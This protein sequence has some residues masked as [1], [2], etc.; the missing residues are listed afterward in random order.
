MKVKSAWKHLSSRLLLLLDL[1]QSRF[2]VYQRQIESGIFIEFPAFSTSP[3]QYIIQF[4]TFHG[5]YFLAVSFQLLAASRAAD[6]LI[7]RW[8]SQCDCGPDS[9]KRC[10]KSFEQ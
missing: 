7:L 9:L 5:R 2:L 3:P 1:R 4:S 10:P 6:T 8:I